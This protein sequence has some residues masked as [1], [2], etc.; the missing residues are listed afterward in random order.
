MITEDECERMNDDIINKLI[1]ECAYINN[2]TIN[3]MMTSVINVL[4]F[5][6]A[7]LKQCEKIYKNIKHL[8]VKYVCHRHNQ[9]CHYNRWWT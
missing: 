2:W 9:W 4:N 8:Y 1:N 6:K 7:A 5:F 3:D